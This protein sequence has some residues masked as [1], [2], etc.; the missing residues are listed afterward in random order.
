MSGSAMGLVMERYH[1]TTPAKYL[2]LLII[3]DNTEI[4]HGVEMTFDDLAWK[5]RCST[6]YMRRLIRGLQN[7]GVLIVTSGE[8]SG[9]HLFEINASALWARPAMLRRA[10]RN[11][12][13]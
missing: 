5:C 6:E 4:G 9:L 2:C 13:R 10:D 8:L 12:A 11:I 3:A 1:P 7:D